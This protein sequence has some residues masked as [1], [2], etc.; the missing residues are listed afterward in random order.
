M[1]FNFLWLAIILSGCTTVPTS[2]Q[3]LD[4]S[5]T[6][7]ILV[8]ASGIHAKVSLWER[9]KAWI[10]TYAADAVI[11][12][13]GLAKIDAKKE[14]DGTTPQGV[15]NLTRA[16]G[17]DTTL[18]TG[19]NYRQVTSEDVWVDDVNSNDYNQWVQ[20]TTA[21]S[22][23]KLRRDDHLYRMAAVIEYNTDTI[24]KGNGSAIFMHIWRKYYKPTAGCVA[25]SERNLKR[26]L[27][28]LNV[29]R[30]PVIILEDSHGS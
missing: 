23:E 12:R 15:F 25:L 8:K 22:F 13:N 19:L 20:T 30:K 21:T 18:A 27:S 14:G 6:Q 2:I 1:R 10:R 16:F 17:Y 24:V 5:H 28:K 9:N 11:G 7:A 26:I 4:P 3:R 29:E